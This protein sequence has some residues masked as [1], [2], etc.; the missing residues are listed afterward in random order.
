M[1]NNADTG[2]PHINKLPVEVS[3]LYLHYLRHQISASNIEI[4]RK[5]ISNLSQLTQ[6]VASFIDSF[7]DLVNFTLVHKPFYTCVHS[8]QSG[9]LWVQLFA[10]HYDLPPQKLGRELKPIYL[11]RNKIIDR[12]AFCTFNAGLRTFERVSLEMIKNLIVDSYSGVSSDSQLGVMTSKNIQ[13]LRFIAQKSR[14]LENVLCHSMQSQGT[15]N[16]LLHAV[17]VIFLPWFL[18]PSL[19]SRVPHVARM[20]EYSQHAVYQ[21]QADVA[22]FFNPQMDRLNLE[23]VLH[24]GNFFKHHLTEIGALSDVHGAYARLQ[25]A[26]RPQAWR[27]KLAEGVTTLTAHWIGAYSSYD[28]GNSD[29]DLG[30]F[31]M[32]P[33]T[34]NQVIMDIVNGGY[35]QLATL[36]LHFDCP[37]DW[38]P[39]FDRHLKR[40]PPTKAGGAPPPHLTFGGSE[41]EF[42]RTD[43]SATRIS[44]ILHAIPPQEGVPGWQRVSFMSYTLADTHRLEDLHTDQ[45]LVTKLEYLRC[46][47]G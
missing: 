10:N 34:S 38:I 23:Y 7:T 6:H 27:E 9:G 11:L 26:M 39:A 14:I 46:Y 17:Q 12:L 40:L 25:A 24:I 33:P 15:S 36:K 16:P 47:E 35:E 4:D 41:G 13:C 5:L 37:V 44:G 3:Y 18:D 30:V 29:V 28:D 8:S 20:M 2:Y 42:D 1:S 21:S 43:I 22:L 19:N 31:R 45:D 32:N